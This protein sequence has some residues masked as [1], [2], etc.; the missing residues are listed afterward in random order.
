MAL[1]AEYIVYDMLGNVVTQKVILSNT[2]QINIS[3]ASGVY[4]DPQN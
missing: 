4:G 2:E 3:A 1:K